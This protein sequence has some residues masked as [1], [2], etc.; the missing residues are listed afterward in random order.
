MTEII[1]YTLQIP[2]FIKKTIVSIMLIKI[3]IYKIHL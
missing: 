1:F 3:W 2:F